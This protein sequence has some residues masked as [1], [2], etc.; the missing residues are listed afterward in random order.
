MI[1]SKQFIKARNSIF[2]KKERD[3]IRLALLQ[4]LSDW[5]AKGY[6]QDQIAYLERLIEK[7][8]DGR[9]FK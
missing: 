2:N 1:L 9:N 6:S 7:F 4:M 3:Y 8:N 5:T